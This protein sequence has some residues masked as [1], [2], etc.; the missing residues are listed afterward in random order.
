MRRLALL[1][2]AL[3]TACVHGTDPDFAD[4]TEVMGGWAFQRLPNAACARFTAPLTFYMD[5]LPVANGETLIIADWWDENRWP[6]QRAVEGTIHGRTRAV[7]LRMWLQF[8]SFVRMGG[9]IDSSGQFV[10][11][12]TAT[13]PANLPNWVTDSLPCTWQVTGR[14]M[15]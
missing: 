4:A 5:M 13:A 8:P 14:R 11:A 6:L 9:T 15:G 10:G 7:E 2:I 3:V 12:I 1:L